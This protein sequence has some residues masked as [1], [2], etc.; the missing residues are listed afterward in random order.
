MH[1]ILVTLVPRYFA[2]PPMK[3]IAIAAIWLC[4]CAEQR[5]KIMTFNLRVGS[6]WAAQR[7]GRHT[8]GNRAELVATTIRNEQNILVVG[9]Q[10][11][12]RYQL[13]FLADKLEFGWVGSGRIGD[14][15]DD[16]EYSALLFNRTLLTVAEEG[17]FWLSKTPNTSA[18]KDWGAALPR[19]ASWAA[20]S[21]SAQNSQAAGIND[22]E[23]SAELHPDRQQCDGDGQWYACSDSNCDLTRSCS[24]NSELERCACNHPPAPSFVVINTHFDHESRKA[25]DY[26]ALLIRA[27]VEALERRFGVPVL[28]LGDFNMPKDSETMWGLLTATDEGLSQVL[29]RSKVSMNDLH[30]PEDE[31][32]HAFALGVGRGLVDVWDA[33]PDNGRDCGACGQS[34]YHAFEG[35]AVGNHHWA[36]VSSAE[37]HL[38]VAR[39]GRQHID[40]ILH[41]RGGSSNAEASSAFKVHSVSMLTETAEEPAAGGTVEFEVGASGNGRTRPAEL[42]PSDHYPLVADVTFE[43]E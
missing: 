18:T 29:Q 4:A 14:D 9:T 5:G 15:S 2:L 41:G 16:D 12:L 22:Y 37:E 33:A 17:T 42:F 39:A 20:F 26:S 13:E 40:W 1:L 28:V 36:E 38:R 21:F 3:L 27:Y 19:I 8:W 31:S 11:G 10:E 25:R 32:H 34:T 7:D 6:A 30:F 24:T 35:S 43:A 23:P